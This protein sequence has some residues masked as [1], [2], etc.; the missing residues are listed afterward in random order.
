M[1]SN[2]KE[3]DQTFTKEESEEVA[4]LK[5][6]TILKNEFLDNFYYVFFIVHF[7]TSLFIDLS[8][9]IGIERMYTKNLILNY[10]STY[11]DFLLFERPAWFKF[12]I[13]METVIQVPMFM[14]F[15]T[16]FNRFYDEKKKHCFTVLIK[17]ENLFRLKT[18]RP[19]I[20]KVLKV[21]G[22][23]ASSTTAYCCYIIFTQGHY[24]ATSIPLSSIDTYKLIALY[25]PMIYIP[26]GLLL[27]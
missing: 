3:A 6:Q 22:L 10:I 9:L 27:F 16:I 12:L 20:R 1:S 21:Y 5:E 18:W 24:P 15:F 7:F 25:S 26:L 8:G 17:K 4:I 11:N 19:I 14:W 13:F 2:T 23:I